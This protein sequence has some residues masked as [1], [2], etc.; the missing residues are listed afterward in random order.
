M[1]VDVARRSLRSQTSLRFSPAIDPRFIYRG[2][3]V[4]RALERICGEVGYPRA[5]RVDQGSEFI[6]R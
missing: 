3:D 6:S 2:E 1:P 5:I 4:V